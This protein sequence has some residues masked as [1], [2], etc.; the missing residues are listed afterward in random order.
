[1]ALAVF[2]TRAA[3]EYRISYIQVDLSLTMSCKNLHY[4]KHKPPIWK[5]SLHHGCL[6]QH[7]PNYIIR[8]L[9]LLLFDCWISRFSVVTNFDIVPHSPPTCFLAPS[10]SGTFCL[11]WHVQHI[12]YIRNQA[13]SGL[14]ILIRL[15]TA[16]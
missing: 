1:V 12:V 2:N 13:P 7:K 9:Y 11:H 15:G 14:S 6:N 5:F 16:T 8:L 4:V 3:P 10:N